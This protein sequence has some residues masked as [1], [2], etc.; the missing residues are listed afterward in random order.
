ML[1]RAFT[2]TLLHVGC[3]GSAAFALGCA[4]LRGHRA[5]WLW[6]AAVAAYALAVLVHGLYDLCV[7]AAPAWSSAALLVILPLL[8]VSLSAA[9]RWGRARSAEFHPRVRA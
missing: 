6:P 5:R 7:F 1:P 4:R 3:T 9:V 8:L 2:S